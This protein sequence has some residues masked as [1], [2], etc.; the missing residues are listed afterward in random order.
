MID[1]CERPKESVRFGCDAHGEILDDVEHF[2]DRVK[3][4]LEIAQVAVHFVQRGE[5]LNELVHRA[6]IAIE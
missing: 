4:I 1:R 6:W 3:L 5:M 2:R